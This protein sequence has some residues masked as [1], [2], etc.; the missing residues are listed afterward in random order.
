MDSIFMT[1]LI[2]FGF[3][4]SLPTL[5]KVDRPPTLNPEKKHVWF[6]TC[7][8]P[9]CRLPAGLLWDLP[10]PHSRPASSWGD[11]TL[12]CPPWAPTALRRTLTDHHPWPT[13]ARASPPHVLGALSLTP[14]PGRRH[15]G[16]CWWDIFPKGRRDT[17]PQ[18]VTSL[19]RG[20]T[21]PLGPFLSLRQ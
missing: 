17:P 7:P 2:N 5:S 10:T 16:R 18:G 4:K 3:D 8:V 11:Q 12:Q 21:Q 1:C 19:P 9:P 14:S 15:R 13:C 6:Y 20:L